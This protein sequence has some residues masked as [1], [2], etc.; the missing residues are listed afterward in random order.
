MIL[1]A[2]SY[3]VYAILE[4]MPALEIDVVEKCKYVV[5]AVKPQ[6]M[7]TTLDTIKDSVTKDTVLVSIAAGITSEFINQRHLAMLK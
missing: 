1:T 4:L 5:L 7:D 3:Q 2:K 6:V